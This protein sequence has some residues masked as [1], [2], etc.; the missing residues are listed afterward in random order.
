[1]INTW[2]S[3]VVDEHLSGSIEFLYTCNHYLAALLYHWVLTSS[4]LSLSK[5][6]DCG[7]GLYKYYHNM[8]LVYITRKHFKS[9]T[10]TI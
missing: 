1:M 10:L 2:S 7:V 6:V 3:F 8:S 5:K 9:Y 4:H